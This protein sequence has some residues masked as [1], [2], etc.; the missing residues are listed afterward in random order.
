MGSPLPK[1]YFE[2]LACPACGAHQLLLTKEKI[3]VCHSCL[4]GYR[5]QGDVPDFRLQNAIS[6]KKARDKTKGMSAQIVVALGRDKNKTVHVTRNHC[7]VIGR[8]QKQAIEDSDLTIVGKPLSLKSYANLDPANQQLIE[9][10]LMKKQ[11][12][13][14]ADRAKTI[15]RHKRLIGQYERDPD[16]TLEDGSVSRAH[17]LIYQDDHGLHILDLLSKNGTYLNGYEIESSRLKNN[18][19]ISLGTAS[20]RV[21]IQ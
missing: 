21:N 9:R 14:P 3:V 19:V 5:M 2:S 16:L 7:L 10:Y 6:L 11:P 18:D 12:K 15:D 20:L 4:N 1:S 8:Q 13:Q 17:A